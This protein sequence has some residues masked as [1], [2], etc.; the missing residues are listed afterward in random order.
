MKSRE[1][2]IPDN[3]I[4]TN[5]GD[6]NLF[7]ILGSGIYFFENE[8]D[9]YSTS[10]IEND[11]LIA[12]EQVITYRNRPSR[13]NMQPVPSS[14][15]FAKMKNTLKVIQPNQY[16][17]DNVIFSTGFCGIKA[18]NIDCSFLFQVLKSENFNTKKDNLAEGTTQVAVNN[19]HVKN[20]EFLLPCSISEQ[21]KIASILSKLDEAITHTEQ[22][23]GKYKKIKEG[24]MHD[25]LT[26]GIDEQGNIRSE[27]THKFKDS[28]LG[29]I[30]LEWEVDKLGTII[31]E[32]NGTIQT[33][34]FGSQLHAN[35][36]IEEGIPVIMPQNILQEGID[37]GTLSFISKTKA[38]ILKRHI[39]NANDIVFAR[40][41]DLSKCAVI[42]TDFIGSICGTGCLLIRINKAN[43]NPLWL[44]MLYQQFNCQKEINIS[45]VGST[46]QNLNTEILSNL[47]IPKISRTEQNLIVEKIQG[48]D[49]LIEKSIHNHIK[50]SKKKSGLMHDLLTGK[51]RVQI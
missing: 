48:I 19:Q 2:K 21:Q 36:Y 40:R 22:L 29:R 34:P 44:R 28:P 47:V 42:E 1:I 46:M 6:K 8:K 51:T 7:E 18:N 26:R 14:V 17:I 27:L 39:T 9:Y 43:I 20:I 11:E 31:S 24:L 13:A 37:K 50:I 16:Q 33:G 5:F 25:L 3:W 32:G 30:P 23:I 10:S 4:L 41:G 49:T 38:N 12:V 45:S 15:W 35:E